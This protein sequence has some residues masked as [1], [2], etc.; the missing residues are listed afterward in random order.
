MC[1]ETANF[2]ISSYDKLHFSTQ[3]GSAQSYVSVCVLGSFQLKVLCVDHTRVLVL[4]SHI[5]GDKTVCRIFMKFAVAV[6][7]KTFS[8]KR[9]FCEN[10]L[11]NCHTFIVQLFTVLFI[12]I[13]PNKPTAI[14]VEHNQG[15]WKHKT[16]EIQKQSLQSITFF[17]RLNALDCTKT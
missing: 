16:A 5:I 3:P 15:Q 4:M 10:R 6:L 14:S 9:P 12:N 8:S 1:C 11:S 2:D 13:K 7:Y 17:S